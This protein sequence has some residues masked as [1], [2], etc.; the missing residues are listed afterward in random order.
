M[1]QTFVADSVFNTPRGFQFYLDTTPD[2]VY[3]ALFGAQGCRNTASMLGR[4]FDAKPLRPTFATAPG[5]ELHLNSGSAII[6]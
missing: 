1:E 6:S 4:V 3:A 5:S 2:A